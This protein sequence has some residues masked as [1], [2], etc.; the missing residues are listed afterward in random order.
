M[1][2]YARLAA[3]LF[4]SP[5]MLHAPVRMQ[6]E[7]ELLQRMGYLK[8]APAAVIIEQPVPRADLGDPGRPMND[9]IQYS[10]DVAAT[11]D[12]LR[13][14]SI[15]TRIGP[16]MIIN[17]DGVIDK[18]LTQF[19][20][21]CY[22]G[23]DLNDVDAVLSAAASDPT[24]T[25]V[26]L[27]INSPGGSC[28]GVQET[29]DRLAAMRQTMEIHAFIDRLCCSAA[30]P[31]AQQADYVVA[32]PSALIGNM[33]VYSAVLDASAWYREQGF[34]PQIIYSG[35]W[36]T[37]GTDTRPLTPEE[38][39]LIQAEVIDIHNRFKVYCQAVR[40]IPD[41]AME[42]QTYE[43]QKTEGLNMVNEITHQ[44]LDEYVAALLLN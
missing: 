30:F 3:K 8:N 25:T 39:A 40:P 37:L 29:C 32:A 44:T 5:L 35:K 33:G 11:Q 31:I 15:A 12:T 23:V 27:R 41:S 4:A 42:A 14:E 20:M 22:G 17:I 19:E 38:T 6:F 13:L 21:D 34:N 1:K 7:R 36:K 26:V 43:A 18:C 28:I 9:W 10:R 16:V 24:I 2:S